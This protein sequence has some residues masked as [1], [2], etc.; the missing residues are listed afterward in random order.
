MMKRTPAASGRSRLFLPPGELFVS[1]KPCTISTILGSCVAVCL[2]DQTLPAGGIA[3]FLLPEGPQG[4]EESDTSTRY[5]DIAISQLIERM[6]MLGS[7]EA[8]LRAKIFGGA[9]LLLGVRPHADGIG[10][11]NIVMAR[12]ALSAMGIP[13]V[14][15]DLGGTRGRKLIYH[16]DTGTAWVGLT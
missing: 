8:N 7:L 14:A 15:E 16:L 13:I 9:S 4:P 3:H 12:Q 10:E 2:W 6:F 1:D 11:R 5:G